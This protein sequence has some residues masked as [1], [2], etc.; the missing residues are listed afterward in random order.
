MKILGPWR[1]PR[2]RT[3]L[4]GS[5]LSEAAIGVAIRSCPGVQPRRSYSRLH[6]TI[7]DSASFANSADRFANNFASDRKNPP[8]HHTPLALDPD[9]RLVHSPTVA[10][11][12]ELR[13]QTSFHF[14]GV[15]L[16]PPPHRDVIGV[17][18]ALSKEFLHVPVGQ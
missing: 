6:A 7:A 11:R 16:H 8:I 4:P 18:A 14:R 17:Q 3:V 13:A 10:R 12:F 5:N 9:V 2:H 15:T 1:R